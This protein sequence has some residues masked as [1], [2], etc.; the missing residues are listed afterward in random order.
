VRATPASSRLGA[1]EER[2]HVS[3][4]LAANEASDRFTLVEQIIVVT[5]VAVL[6]LIAIPNP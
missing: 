1:S 2:K 3:K 5:T 6:A 4:P